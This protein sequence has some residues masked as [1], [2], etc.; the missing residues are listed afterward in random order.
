MATLHKVMFK[1]QKKKKKKKEFLA[2]KQLWS[3]DGKLMTIHFEDQCLVED[4]KNHS[5]YFALLTIN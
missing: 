1:L 5:C 4:S 2:K 3:I